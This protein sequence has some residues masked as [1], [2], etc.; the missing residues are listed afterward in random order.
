M[1]TTI[2]VGTI[3]RMKYQGEYECAKVVLLPPQFH[4]GDDKFGVQHFE[5]SEAEMKASVKAVWKNGGTT[6]EKR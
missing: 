4:K 3:V 6:L 2:P 5:A 1:K